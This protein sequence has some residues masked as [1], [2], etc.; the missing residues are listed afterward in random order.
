MEYLLSFLVFVEPF[1]TTGRCIDDNGWRWSS[2]FILIRAV[3][4]FFFVL[5]VHHDHLGVFWSIREQ[6]VRG[7]K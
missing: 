6:I 1:D 3:F 4:L 7:G 5:R 2:V